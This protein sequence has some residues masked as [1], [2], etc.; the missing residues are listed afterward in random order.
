MFYTFDRGFSVMEV[1]HLQ[2]GCSGGQWCPQAVAGHQTRQCEV[3]VVGFLEKPEDFVSPRQLG[4]V[5]DHLVLDA[6]LVLIC[7]P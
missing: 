2:P 5:Q 3:M 1:L 7:T 6:E 4:M